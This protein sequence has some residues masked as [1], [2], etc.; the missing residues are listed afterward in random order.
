MPLAVLP[1]VQAK[2]GAM[3][4]EMR[5]TSSSSGG[6]RP[7]INRRVSVF[8]LGGGSRIP[9]AISSPPGRSRSSGQSASFSGGLPGGGSA[10]VNGTGVS[11]RP[12]NRGGDGNG[13]SP[14]GAGMSASA[15]AATPPL[16]KKQAQSQEDPEMLDLLRNQLEQL[17][18][19]KE[20]E[21]RG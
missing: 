2:V 10:G 19:A 15:S 12:Q 8:D 21:V 5:G 14:G 20:A 9:S 6:G 7:S 11:P 18:M 16:R 3:A 13:R 4:A 17:A 1:D